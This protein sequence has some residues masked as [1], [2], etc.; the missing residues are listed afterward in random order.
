MRK[1]VDII[2]IEGYKKIEIFQHGN[3]IYFNGNFSLPKSKEF[4]TFEEAKEYAEGIKWLAQYCSG[5]I[6]HYMKEIYFRT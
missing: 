5:T 6:N 3:R 4:E 1:L 2:K